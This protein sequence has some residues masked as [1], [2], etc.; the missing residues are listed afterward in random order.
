MLLA[1]SPDEVVLDALE[2]LSSV[3]AN[4]QFGASEKANK[5]L[6]RELTEDLSLRFADGEVVRLPKRTKFTVYR[7]PTGQPTT[8]YVASFW[9]PGEIINVLGR[10]TIMRR[11]TPLI[12]RRR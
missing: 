3:A 4:H 6:D 12:T 2:W 8:T 10:G 1:S 11:R 7:K 5:N 9:L